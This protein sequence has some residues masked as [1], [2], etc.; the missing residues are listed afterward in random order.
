MIALIVRFIV[1]VAI[2]GIAFSLLPQSS[3]Q[4]KPQADPRYDKSAPSAALL[5]ERG[6][7]LATELKMLKRSREA[8]GDRHPTL[9]VINKQIEA[10]EEQLKAWEP[11]FGGTEANPFRPDDAKQA[12]QVNEYDLRQ[13]VIRLNARVEELEKR[14]AVLEKKTK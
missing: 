9:P 8:M 7:Q 11:A 5:T 12:P 10:I 13:M 1:C 4:T 3:A 2:V 14:V 6:R